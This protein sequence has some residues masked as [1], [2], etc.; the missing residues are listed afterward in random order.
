MF[1]RKY[2]IRDSVLKRRKYDRAKESNDNNNN[3]EYDD[4]E[5][6]NDLYKKWKGTDER[7]TERLNAKI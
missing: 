7:K 5:G 4:D 3:N 6:G 1:L 2:A